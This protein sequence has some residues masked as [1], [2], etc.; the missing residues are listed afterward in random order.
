[1]MAM[2]VARPPP[3]VA[4]EHGDVGVVGGDQVGRGPEVAF[5]IRGVLEELAIARE[6]PRRWGDVAAT[7]D[8]EGVEWAVG[9]DPS[10]SRRRRHDDV[11]SRGDVQRA[12][13]RLETA[14]PFLD[15]HELVADRVSVQPAVAVGDSPR[16]LDVVVRQQRHPTADEVGFS[17]NSQLACADVAWG[18]WDISD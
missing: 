6:V 2:D 16:E 11:V 3:S 5:A 8:D 10:M 14:P 18:E 15:E 17:G 1:M 4:D 12:E 13:D 9:D 7:G